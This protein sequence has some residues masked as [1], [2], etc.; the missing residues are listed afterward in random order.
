MR[1]LFATA[2]AVIVLA[3]PAAAQTTSADGP[4]ADRAAGLGVTDEAAFVRLATSSNILEIRSSMLARDRSATDA[5]KAFA[6]R[7]IA[8]HTA[9]SEELARVSGIT[10]LDL[11]GDVS[12]LLD[13]VHAGLLAEVQTAEGAAFDRAYVRL[14]VQAHE[15]AV[16]L[17]QS[18][19]TNGEEGEVK[20]FAEAALPKLQ[21]HFN[22]AQDLNQGQ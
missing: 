16:A 18:Y 12:A 6:A 8:E 17:F 5:V 15:E 19:A 9:A 7:M 11:S 13:P 4:A 10:A 14:Q 21:A 3:M 2:L 20:A 1:R 22:M